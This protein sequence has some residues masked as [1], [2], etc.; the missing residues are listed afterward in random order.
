MRNPQAI[1][2]HLDEVMFQARKATAIIYSARTEYLTAK[3]EYLKA[4]K[5]S[6][7]AATGTVSDRE[8]EAQVANWDS[9]KAMEIA[10]AA[11]QHA[12]ELRKD[13]EDELSKLQTEARL[14][15]DEMGLSR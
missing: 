2:A 15:R 13:L 6:K 7:L 3:H 10:E 4:Y 11:L 8:D 5:T 1:I 12:R 14:V 9:F